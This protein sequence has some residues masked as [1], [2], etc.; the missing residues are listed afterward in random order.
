MVFMMIYDYLQLDLVKYFQKSKRIISPIMPILDSEE[1]MNI[2][3]VNYY[4]NYIDY[5]D[6]IDYSDELF[7]K[8]DKIV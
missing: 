5:I 6:Y 3:C 7:D 8:L 4:I 2:N 1:H